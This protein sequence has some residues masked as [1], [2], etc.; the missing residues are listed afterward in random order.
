M[1]RLDVDN[2]GAEEFSGYISHERIRT[3]PTM[4]INKVSASSP[5]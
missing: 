2:Q 3:H 4:V 1:S 5:I